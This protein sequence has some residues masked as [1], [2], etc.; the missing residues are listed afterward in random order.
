MTPDVSG[1]RSGRLVTAD[2]S[3]VMARFVIGRSPGADRFRPIG[4]C[5]GASADGVC[6]S[7]ARW[8]VCSGTPATYPRR[9]SLEDL[10]VRLSDHFCSR[11]CGHRSTSLSRRS[12]RILRSIV[13]DTGSHWWS[14]RGFSTGIDTSRP[15]L[16]CRAA[17]RFVADTLARNLDYLTA[18]TLVDRVEPSHTVRMPT[19]T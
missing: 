7:T 9:S 13:I 18:D 16:S 12:R 8:S 2:A 5:C 11:W 4:E 3:A 1:A 14:A 6:M 19:R 17:R 10:W 15:T